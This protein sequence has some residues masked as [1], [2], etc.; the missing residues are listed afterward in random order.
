MNTSNLPI[1]PVRELLIAGAEDLFLELIDNLDPIVIPHADALTCT[2]AANSLYLY[3]G[4]IQDLSDNPSN[5]QTVTESTRRKG[6]LTIKKD[7]RIQVLESSSK[8]LLALMDRLLISP[9]TRMKLIAAMGH[10][11]SESEIKSS[12]A[13]DNFINL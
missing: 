4:V 8:Q 1:T 5:G 7:A 6:S 2:M 12:E 10:P 3:A 11:V 9:Q 13:I